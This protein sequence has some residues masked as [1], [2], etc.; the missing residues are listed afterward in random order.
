MTKSIN[1]IARMANVSVTTV[2]LVINDQHKKYRISE[3]TRKRIQDIIDEHGYYINQTARSLKL[4]KSQTLGLVVPRI[5]NAFFAALTEELEWLCRN[6]GFQLITIC[7]DENDQIERKITENLYARGV[8]GMFVCSTN[9]SCQQ[10]LHDNQWGKP[11]VFLDRDFDVADIPMVRSDHYQGAFQLG[12][13]LAN[14]DE[15]LFLAG[16]ISLPSMQARLKGVREG[17]SNAGSELNDNHIFI[18]DKGRHVDGYDLMKHVLE[19]YHLDSQTIV[20]ASLPVLEGAIECMKHVTGTIPKGLTIACF[21]DHAMLDFLPN[22]VIAV[23]QDT[24]ALATSASEL[25]SCL[26]DKKDG[27]THRYILAPKMI[28]RT[29]V[30]S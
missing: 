14:V 15:I 10:E 7:S 5:T 16:N 30:V 22:E 26:L 13:N 2:R 18:A 8:D 21:D 29:R 17:I 24:T 19:N 4:N 25:M 11:I 6:N 28:T 20:L 12:Q 9:L 3:Q 27:F 23:K 1:E